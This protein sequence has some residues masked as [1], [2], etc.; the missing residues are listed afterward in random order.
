MR[1]Y[2]DRNRLKHVEIFNAVGTSNPSSPDY[3]S[4]PTIFS[5]NKLLEIPGSTQLTVEPETPQEVM[6]ALHSGRDVKR[7]NENTDENTTDT[8]Q[9]S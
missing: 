5:L 7:S 3:I 8:T 4:I 6:D 2:W 1:T 9:S